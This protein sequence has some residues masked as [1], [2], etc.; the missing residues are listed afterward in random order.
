MKTK[1]YITV[2]L[3]TISFSDLLACNVCG[4]GV[5]N[6]HYG[7]LPQFQKNFVGLRYRYRSYLSHLEDGHMA[8]HSSETFQ[9]A[10][11]WGRFYPV[12]RLQAFV[13]IPYNINERQEGSKMTYLRGIGDVFV[14]P[15]R[16]VGDGRAAAAEHEPEHDRQQQREQ[17]RRL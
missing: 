1:I 4:C 5:G 6:Y 12:E 9:S 3:F 16:F 17:R 11:L 7:I 10:E 13:F 15:H 2:I 8:H 14:E